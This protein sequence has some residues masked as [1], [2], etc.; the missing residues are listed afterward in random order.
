M[1]FDRAYVQ[2]AV[3][4]P[5][6]NSFLTGRRPDSTRVWNFKWNFRELSNGSQW[7]SLPQAFKKQGYITSGMGKVYHPGEPKND[8]V[9]LSWSEEYT[10]FNPMV[11]GCGE[12]DYA[13]QGHQW[14]ARMRRTLNSQ[15]ARLHRRQ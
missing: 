1:G 6:R 14:C 8:D 7:I 2:I 10:Y 11:D 9:P 13:A 12:G 15:M 3:C 4:S 5:S